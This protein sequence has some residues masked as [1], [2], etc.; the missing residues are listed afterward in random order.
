MIT[1]YTVCTYDHH[2]PISPWVLFAAVRVS[3]KEV[4]GEWLASS[5]GRQQLQDVARHFALDRDVFGSSPQCQPAM[6]V[7][8]RASSPVHFGNVLSPA[9]VGRNVWR[10][11]NFHMPSMCVCV[12]LSVRMTYPPSLALVI[13]MPHDVTLTPLVIIQLSFGHCTMH[14]SWHIWLLLYQ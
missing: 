6:T 8:Y 10:T 9:Q 12:C 3:L 13:S 4:Q 7:L 11:A 1:V 5:R 14:L 2:I